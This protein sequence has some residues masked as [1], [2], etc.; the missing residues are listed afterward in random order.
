MSKNKCTATGVAALALAMWVVNAHAVDVI[1]KGKQSVQIVVV[2]ETGRK[3]VTV[4]AGGSVEQ[5]CTACTIEAPSGAKREVAGDQKVTL[6]G[7][8][9]LVSG[10]P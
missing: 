9:L 10:Q 1:N 5:V 6:S 8:L 3:T 7:P 2:S 4:P